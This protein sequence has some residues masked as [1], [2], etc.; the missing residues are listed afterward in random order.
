MI[1][2]QRVLIFAARCLW[3]LL[4]TKRTPL[5]LAAGNGQLDVCN[6]LLNMKADVNATDIVRSLRSAE[7]QKCKTP[8]PTWDFINSGACQNSRC[9]WKSQDEV[10]TK[11]KS[12][13]PNAKRVQ[14]SVN[15]NKNSTITNKQI[16]KKWPPMS[17]MHW[18]TKMHSIWAHYGWLQRQLFN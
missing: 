3:F 10:H 11:R 8:G 15:W 14:V 9:A 2:C 7:L 5:H 1:N 6:S 13:R 16:N 17:F 18:C 4:Q 12:A